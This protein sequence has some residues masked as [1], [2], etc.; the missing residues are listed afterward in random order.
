[1]LQNG[2]KSKIIRNGLEMIQK[3][4]E[5]VKND[6]KRPQNARKP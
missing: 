6:A 2:K 1:M 5:T 4:W 3:G